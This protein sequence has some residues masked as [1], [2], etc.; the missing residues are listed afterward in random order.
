MP[1]PCENCPVREALIELATIARNVLDGTLRFTW[2]EKAGYMNE[3]DKLI[4][5]MSPPV[6]DEVSKS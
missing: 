6:S 1:N 2:S 5:R 4:K 3:V